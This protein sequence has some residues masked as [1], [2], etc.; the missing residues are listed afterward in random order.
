MRAKVTSLVILS[1][2][3]AASA[4]FVSS[5]RAS[6]PREHDKG[7]FLRLSAGGGGARTTIDDVPVFEGEE[8]V[9]LE[10]SGP[11]GDVN[12]AIGGTVSP[13]L[14]SH[15]TLAGW[16]VSD[17][18]VD[19][20]P[21][22]VEIDDAT[23]SLSMFGAGAT[24]YFMP[25]NIYISGSI[26]AAMLT[27]EVDGDEE[28]SDTGIAVDLTAGKEWWVGN[29]WGLGVAVG[30]NLHSVPASDFEDKNFS[31]SSFAIRFSA[32]LN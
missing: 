17:P 3:A 8:D 9:D 27:S 22:D 14:A 5:A 1:T 32:T 15:A 13:N 10:F 20:G 30:A 12:F 28:E 25:A 2:L 4:C 16:S 6:Q 11:A 18:E 21:I 31:G 19:L 29:S 24:Y 7:F 23:L 26:G